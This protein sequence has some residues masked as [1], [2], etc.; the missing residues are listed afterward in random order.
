MA[1]KHGYKIHIVTGSQLDREGCPHCGDKRGTSDLLHRKTD[2]KVRLR[3]SGNIYRYVCG[4][5]KRVSIGISGKI[6]PS[7]RTALGLDS[8]ITIS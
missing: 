5:C 7:L 6:H 1:K 4:G 3:S 2:L 8:P